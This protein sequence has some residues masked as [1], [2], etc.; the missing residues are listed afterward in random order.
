MRQI[1]KPGIALPIAFAMS[2]LIALAALAAVGWLEMSW[3]VLYYGASLITYRC[4]ARDKQP[5]RMQAG[6]PLSRPCI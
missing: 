5:L 3:L 2:F 4:Y 1:L 6:E